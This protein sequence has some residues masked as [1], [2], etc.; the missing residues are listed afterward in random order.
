M[1]RWRSR[2]SVNGCNVFAQ[3]ISIVVGAKGVLFALVFGCA[4][5]LS[6]NKGNF[7]DK[8]ARAALLLARRYNPYTHHITLW[9]MEN[10]L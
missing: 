3:H 8:R 4:A 7:Y 9:D 10:V 6:N 5:W 2:R 1:I